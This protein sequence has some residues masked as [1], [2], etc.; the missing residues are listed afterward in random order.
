VV[1][2]IGG[3]IGKVFKTVTKP[4]SGIL[5]PFKGILGGILNKL[6]FGN[7]IKGFLG[8]FLKGPLSM[9]A[10]PFLGP[11]A[12]ILGGAGGLGSLLGAGQML[13]GGGGLDH[14]QAQHNATELFA[15][16]AARIF[17]RG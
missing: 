11:L 16:N 7:V 1:R 13:A 12:G 5:K 9:L 17:F 6:P 2:R 10:A 8:K 14:P 15:Q 3:G 4:L